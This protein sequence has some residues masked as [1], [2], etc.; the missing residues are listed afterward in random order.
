MLLV[1]NQ[2]H[3]SIAF[4]LT[5]DDFHQIR[6]QL[7]LFRKKTNPPTIFMFHGLYDSMEAAR[8]ARNNM[9][10]FLRR[11]HP[12]PLPVDDVLKKLQN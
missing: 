9:P 4:T 10:V 2:A 6:E 8:E 3:A 12:Y 11:H 5:Q 7:F 1:S